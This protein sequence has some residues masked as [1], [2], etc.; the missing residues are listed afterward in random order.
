[1]EETGTEH[2]RAFSFIQTSGVPLKITF[3]CGEEHIKRDV[4]VEVEVCV[5]YKK[6]HNDYR[7]LTSFFGDSW[8]L[9]RG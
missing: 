3:L 1:M 4:L 6:I 2:L 8:L 7:L 9:V 5:R